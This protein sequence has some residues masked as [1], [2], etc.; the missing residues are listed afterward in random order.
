MTIGVRWQCGD[1]TANITNKSKV[2]H[3]VRLVE[4]EMADLVQLQLAG[5]HQVADTA[6]RADHDVGARAHS[7]HLH[8]A[9]DATKDGNDAP[10]LSA[11]RR[12]LCSICN[13][14]SRVGARI[15]ARVMKHAAELIAGQVL[16]HR[17]SECRGLAG[18]GLG[19]A[20]Q[21]AAGEQ[22]RNGGCLDG[23]WLKEAL[24][25]RA[26]SK[27]SARPRVEK[28]FNG[29]KIDAPAPPR[30]FITA[31]KGE[32]LDVRLPARQWGER[33]K[34]EVPGGHAV[35]SDERQSRIHGW[36]AISPTVPASARA[37]RTAKRLRPRVVLRN[38][39]FA[40][41]VL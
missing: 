12:R 1:D 39:L 6:W 26:R 10:P 11:E 34:T 22:V 20:E 24:C 15:R 18:A 4:H 14:S 23:G 35:Q 9:A 5:A 19:D 25:S 7:L 41:R 27:G 29:T 21:V 31:A 36:R 17:Q 13:A 30:A 38:F 37:H 16:E 33:V 2:E 40:R 3:A 32:C 28:V 8:E